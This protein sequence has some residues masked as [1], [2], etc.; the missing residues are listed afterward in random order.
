MDKDKTTARRVLELIVLATILA[1]VALVLVELAANV[2][3][4]LQGARP[5]IPHSRV[6]TYSGL[7]HGPQFP[8]SSW[9]RK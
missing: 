8:A 6:S 2:G 5:R 9:A 3:A 1:C 7:F 4:E